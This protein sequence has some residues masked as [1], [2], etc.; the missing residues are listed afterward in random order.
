V[1]LL[2]LRCSYHT[3]WG[4]LARRACTRLLPGAR[5][6]TA[7][8]NLAPAASQ[9]QPSL[10]WLGA[11]GP[12]AGAAVGAAV[13]VGLRH[14]SAVPYKREQLA[15]TIIDTRRVAS[16][17]GRSAA[18]P[19]VARTIWVWGWGAAARS[20]RGK[21]RWARVCDRPQYGGAWRG[22]PSTPLLQSAFTLFAGSGWCIAASWERI[23][24][25]H[26]TRRARLASPL[27]PCVLT[28]DVS[29]V[30]R[31]MARVGCIAPCA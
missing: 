19:A 2:A 13:A 1:W 6:Q 9:R 11:V 5:P 14:G 18:A 17:R 31:A 26:R 8:P 3:R 16:W 10:T 23:A 27:H 15:H 22:P 7:V 25:R 4:W 24:G 28:A 21:S 20:L 12:R 29:V 30:G